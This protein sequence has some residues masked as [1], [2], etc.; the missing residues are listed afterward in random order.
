MDPYFRGDAYE[1]RLGRA[2]W[3]RPYSQGAPSQ[4]LVSEDEIEAL[5]DELSSTSDRESFNLIMSRFD[6]SFIE[7]Y[8]A[9]YP[10][11]TGLFPHGSGTR[12][13]PAP[14]AV[15]QPYSYLGS[16]YQG[17]PRPQAIQTPMPDTFA[18]S[19]HN[20]YFA[21]PKGFDAPPEYS[22]GRTGPFYSQPAQSYAQPQSFPP[23]SYGAPQPGFQ[24]KISYDP[25]LYGSQYTPQPQPPM[26]SNM[27]LPPQQY[28]G[29]RDP[30]SSTWQ[31]QARTPFNS[32]PTPQSGRDPHPRK[33]APDSLQGRDFL[34]ESKDLR[35]MKED[36]LKQISSPA[37]GQTAG[38][39]PG[40]ALF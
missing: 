19:R 16:L 35:Q 38:A 12:Q 2:N 17:T 36:M 33:F 25:N 34:R 30:L 22:R 20:E 10:P 32:S 31:S 39:Q 37:H 11:T 6:A 13:A 40:R 3:D 23:Q 15:Q 26:F 7:R 9:K 28:P 18:Q 21:Q 29:F 24:Q 14:Q 1:S 8:K 5:I 4:P 27:P